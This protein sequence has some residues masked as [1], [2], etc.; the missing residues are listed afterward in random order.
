MNDVLRQGGTSMAR[1][2][3]DG[4]NL[5]PDGLH[6]QANNKYW[7]HTPLAEA[8]KIDQEAAGEASDALSDQVRAYAPPLYG[9][10]DPGGFSSDVDFAW[11]PGF[12]GDTR[13]NFYDQTGLSQWYWDSFWQSE[14]ELYED[15]TPRADDTT[16]DGV[17]AMGT[18]LYTYLADT[19]VPEDE[20]NGT[21]GEALAFDQLTDWSLEPMSADNARIFL[22][23]GGFPRSAPQPDTPEFRIAVEDLKTRFSTCAWRDPIDP[24][25]VMGD[26]VSTAAAEWQQEIA[27]Q[28]VQ[29]NQILDASTSSTKSLATGARVLGDMLGNSWVA[30]HLVR[31]QAYWAPGGP[32]TEGWSDPPDAGQFVH[33]KE[34]LAKARAS[35]KAQLIQLKLQAAAAKRAATATNT[36]LQAAYA[37]A[38]GNGAPRGR[39]LMAAQQRAQVTAGASAALDAMVAAGQ[40]AEAA[41]HASAADSETITQ[42]AVTKAAQSKAEFRKEAAQ[43]AA[44]QAAAAAAAAKVHRDNAKKDKETAEAKLA[45][46]VKA[47]ADSKAAAADAHAKRLAAEAE[48]KTAKA[49]KATAAAKQSEAAGHKTNAEAYKSAAVAAEKKAD[50]AATTASEKRASAEAARDTAKDK[51][52]DAW[53][54]ELKANAARAKADAKD[55]YA[56]A[57]EADENAGEARTAANQADAAATEAETAAAGART[58]ADAATKAAADADAAATRAEAAAKRARSDADGAQAAKLKAD[59]A[60]MTATSAAADAIEA[61]QHAASEAKAAVELANTAEKKAKDAKADAEVAKKESANAQAAASKAAGFAY[62]TAQA[63]GDAKASAAQVSKPANDAIQLGSPYVSTDATASL[64]VLTGQASKTIAEQQLAVAEAHAKNAQKEAALA[65]SLADKAAAD[66]KAALQSAADAAASAAEARGYSKEALGY[67]AGAAAAAAKA[68]ASLARSTDYAGQAAIDAIAAD[69]AAGRAE[70]YATDARD[71]ADQAALDADAAHAAATA[72]TEAAEKARKAADQADA[73]ATAA[74]EAAKDAQTYADGAQEAAAEAANKAANTEVSTGAGVGIERVFSVIEKMT[75]AAPAKQLNTCDYVPQGC[76]VTYK[77]T[78]NVTASY[79]FCANPDVPAT[80]SG[81][82]KSDAIYLDTLTLEKQEDEWTHHF[83]FGDITR[84]GWQNLFGEKL[85]AIL[86]ELVLGD[87]AKCRHGHVSNCV[88]AAVLVAPPSVFAKLAEAAK[89]AARAELAIKT[90]DDAAQVLADLKKIYGEGGAAQIGNAASAANMGFLVAKG[91]A[92]RA[93]IAATALDSKLLAKLTASGANFN[94]ADTLWIVSYAKPG[95][96]IAWLETGNVNAGLIHIIFRHAG[97]FANAGVRIENIP[98]LV[99]KALT[100][101]ARVGTQNGRPIFEVVFQGKTQ[102]VAISVGDNGY[103]VGANIA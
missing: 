14:S 68:V 87:V 89:L 30:D 43:F 63:A 60:V 96:P 76:T 77:L 59:S 20:R 26:E 75:E 65:Q 24:N 1:I 33:A 101:G 28:A 48:E 92:E 42:L 53:D 61:S 70:G 36:A 64:V 67:S 49:E 58:E 37:I 16:H 55:A 99:S 86:Y 72:A 32:W 57:H 19:S 38:D 31:W 66:T 97:E 44:Q 103:V 71:S 15:P 17:T 4:L 82:P 90:G 2:A 5:P 94:R 45:V 47:E 73:D 69:Q 102:R 29:R 84:L 91:V 18:P 25:K 34:E 12:P 78:V 100:D 52:D 23:S 54:A 46:A 83:S 51:R 27:S 85:G 95:L 50:T 7:N 10:D 8:Y 79:Y 81:C 74:E 41:T 88:M 35:A 56:D 21:Y 40:T 9:L 22:Q 80:E 11:P 98:A 39:G 13:G 3:Q 93:K 62:V 6:I